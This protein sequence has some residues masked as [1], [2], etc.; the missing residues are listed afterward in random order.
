[1]EV[2]LWNNIA[3]AAQSGVS[4]GEVVAAAQPENAG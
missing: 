4:G 3:V 1:V 2:G